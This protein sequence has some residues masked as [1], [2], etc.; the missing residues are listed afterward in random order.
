VYV[1]SKISSWFSLKTG[2]LPANIGSPGCVLNLKFLVVQNN[3]DLGGEID[4]SFLA[5]CDRCDVPGCQPNW[6]NNPMVSPFLSGSSPSSADI[7]LIFGAGPKEA[8]EVSRAQ[9]EVTDLAKGDP[10]CEEHTKHLSPELLAANTSWCLW[11]K[12]YLDELRANAKGRLYVFCTKGC[13]QREVPKQEVHRRGRWSGRQIPD[14]QEGVQ[15]AGF[16]PGV[17][18]RRRAGLPAGHEREVHPRLGE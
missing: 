2:A 8:V 13:F 18:F 15:G 9:G 3:P 16:Q 4:A 6:S 5:N 14:C 12:V 1:A 11:Q 10:D 17:W 7:T